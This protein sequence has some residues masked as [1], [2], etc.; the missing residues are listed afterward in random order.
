MFFILVKNIFWGLYSRRR[1]YSHCFCLPFFMKCLA[2]SA[3]PIIHTCLYK[4][5]SNHNI[6]GCEFGGGE[7]GLGQTG[8]FFSGI[9]PSPPLKGSF[10]LNLRHLF[11]ADRCKKVSK[12]AILAPIYTNFDDIDQST[13]LVLQLTTFLFY[14]N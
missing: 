8:A 2:I 11:W 9:W 14:E 4:R 3:E 5:F 7:G 12:G 1:F 13:Q 6:T 10:S